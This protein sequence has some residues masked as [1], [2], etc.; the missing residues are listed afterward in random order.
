MEESWKM[1]RSAQRGGAGE[2]GDGVALS[3]GAEGI[4]DGWAYT[5]CCADNEDNLNRC[6]RH[7]WKVI[8]LVCIYFEK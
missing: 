5:A 1:H 8:S 2:D 7:L 3:V 4:Y 6:G